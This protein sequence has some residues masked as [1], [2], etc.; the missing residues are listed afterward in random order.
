MLTFINGK[1]KKRFLREYMK[2]T[3]GKIF[4]CKIEWYIVSKIPSYYDLQYFWSS[5]HGNIR[6]LYSECNVYNGLSWMSF[7]SDY[8]LTISIIDVRKAKMG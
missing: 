6:R 5:I 7:I 1:E 3:L 8:R 2:F 4:Y